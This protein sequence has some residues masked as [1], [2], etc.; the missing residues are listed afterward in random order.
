MIE[1]KPCPFC[2]SEARMISAVRWL[3]LNGKRRRTRGLYWYVGCSDPE[4]ILYL[5]KELKNT[6]LIFLSRS[7]G[8][9][10][11]RWNRRVE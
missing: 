7:R 6:R 3:R 10:V 2:K 11:R 8:L 1:L 5:D 4:C 9:V